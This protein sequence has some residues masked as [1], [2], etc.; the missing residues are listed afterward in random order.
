MEDENRPNI[1]TSTITPS[2]GKQNGL[3]LILDQV[4]NRLIQ[5]MNN[6]SISFKVLF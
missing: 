4:R 1:A 2:V 5:I 3:R 6:R